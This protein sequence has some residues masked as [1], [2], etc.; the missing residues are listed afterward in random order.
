M[1]PGLLRGSRAQHGQGFALHFP[2]E[3]VVLWDR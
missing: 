1:T 2:S 3:E